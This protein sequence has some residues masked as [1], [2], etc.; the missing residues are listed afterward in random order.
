MS[1]VNAAIGLAHLPHL[2][3]DNRLR[4]DI[5]ARYRE[6]LAGVA[7]IT[8]TDCASDRTSS[9]HLFCILAENRDRLADALLANGVTVGVHYRRNDSYRIWNRQDLP[10]AEFFCHRVL[11]LPMYPQLGREQQDQVVAVIRKGW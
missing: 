4:A 6:L 5:A 9:H 8:C 11:S 2:D 1:D 3:E 10:G 7:G